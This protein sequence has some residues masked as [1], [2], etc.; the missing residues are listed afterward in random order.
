MN[1]KGKRV[2]GNGAAPYVTITLLIG[3]I[4][5]GFLRIINEAENLLDAGR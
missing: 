5:T 3:D 4:P 2:E 1:G